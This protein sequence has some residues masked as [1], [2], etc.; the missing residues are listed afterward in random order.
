MASFL[1]GDD[2]DVSP[3]QKAFLT[4]AA[5]VPDRLTSKLST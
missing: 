1:S 4:L 3:L 5:K 2:F